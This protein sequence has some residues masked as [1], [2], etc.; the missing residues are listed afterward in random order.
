MYKEPKSI[1]LPTNNE[2][3]VVDDDMDNYDNQIES[4]D[5]VWQ[6]LSYPQEIS[7]DIFAPQ[8]QVDIPN[9]EVGAHDIVRN[10]KKKN[11]F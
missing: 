2:D 1:V 6:D 7:F 8:K 3:D 11:C 4:V 10:K 9:V 5:D